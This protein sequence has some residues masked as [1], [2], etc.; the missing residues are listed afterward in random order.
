LGDLAPG[1]RSRKGL[2]CRP[3]E[4]HK[5][6]TNQ[7]KQKKLAKIIKKAEKKAAK[8]A[9]KKEKNSSTKVDRSDVSLI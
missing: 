8:K 3:K 6:R 4:I 7:V 2:E 1:K 9:A 5:R